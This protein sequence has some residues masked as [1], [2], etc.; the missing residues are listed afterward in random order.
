[1]WPLGQSGTRRKRHRPHHG[2]DKLYDARRSNGHQ[3]AGSIVTSDDPNRKRIPQLRCFREDYFQVF[4]DS[5][6]TIDSQKL[7]YVEKHLYHADGSLQT[8]ELLLPDDN[9]LDEEV[10]YAYGSAGRL[11]SV[12][13][14]DGADGPFTDDLFEAQTIDPWG[15]V[16]QATYGEANGG[17]G[18]V[19]TASY[20]GTGRRLAT[21]MTLTGPLDHFGIS[22]VPNASGQAAFD[23]LAS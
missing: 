2:T 19:F 5:E 9:Y 10:D 17:A 15:R 18:L 12:L 1:M 7:I 16:R 11:A 20:A 8:T 23:P 14:Q 4:T 6:E 21:G 13:Y 3:C 22:F